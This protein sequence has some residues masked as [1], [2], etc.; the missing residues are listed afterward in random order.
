MESPTSPDSGQGG[1]QELDWDWPSATPLLKRTHP[2]D[3]DFADLSDVAG[4]RIRRFI[5]DSAIKGGASPSDVADL[6]T[7]PEIMS[8][9]QARS[10]LDRRYVQGE[11]LADWRRLE[12]E[13]AAAHFEGPPGRSSDDLLARLQNRE[14]T[15]TER[16][17][18][19]FDDPDDLDEVIDARSAPMTERDPLLADLTAESREAIERHIVAEVLGYGIA[20]V[21]AMELR[22][23]LQASGDERALQTLDLPFERGERPPDW[24]ATRDRALRLRS[25]LERLGND[26][27]EIFARTEAAHPGLDA[28]ALLTLIEETAGQR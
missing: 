22:E 27:A 4:E 23:M 18:S 11:V 1:R 2:G 15:P 17:R 19:I 7:A 10:Y 24:D 9:Q 12:D 25:T 16:P 26:P 5:A 28:Q 21:K 3:L 6:Y 14:A 20:P 13:I 8:D